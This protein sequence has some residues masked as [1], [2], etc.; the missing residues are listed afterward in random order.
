MQFALNVDKITVFM[1]QSYQTIRLGQVFW[2]R[3]KVSGLATY[4]RERLGEG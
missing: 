2:I 3:S 4:P 1:S